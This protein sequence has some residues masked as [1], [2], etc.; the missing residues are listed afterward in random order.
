LSYQTGDIASLRFLAANVIYQATQALLRPDTGDEAD[1]GILDDACMMMDVIS[2]YYTETD[3]KFTVEINA[4]RSDRTKAQSTLKPGLELDP[5]IL[6]S[7][8]WREIKAM[9][10]SMCRQGNF[11]RQESPSAEWIPNKKVA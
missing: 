7:Y 9:F 5:A 8:R 4:I 1:R 11:V 3:P 2:S 10:R 6:E